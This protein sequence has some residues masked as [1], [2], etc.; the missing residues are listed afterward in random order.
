MNTDIIAAISTLGFPIIAA[1]ACGYYVT[2]INK[3]SQESIKELRDVIENNTK[4]MIKIC[5]KLGI[6]DQEEK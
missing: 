6:N 1:V 3:Q 5:T 4:V 2:V